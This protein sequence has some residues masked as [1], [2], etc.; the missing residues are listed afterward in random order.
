M[1]K[2]EKVSKIYN[3]KNEPIVAVEDVSFA[4]SE[5]EFVCVVGKS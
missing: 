2:F 1:I 5:G 4:I 3:S